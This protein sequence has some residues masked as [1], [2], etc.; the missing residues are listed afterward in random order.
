L[1]PPEMSPRGVPNPGLHV[2]AAGTRE[3][4]RIVLVD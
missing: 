4:K 3:A 1:P 2:E